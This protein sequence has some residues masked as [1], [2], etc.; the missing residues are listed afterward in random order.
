VIAEKLPESLRRELFA[1][2][3]SSFKDKLFEGQDW[4]IEMLRIANQKVK[5]KQ[6]QI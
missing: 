1:Y 6:M 3:I 5:N 2:S 4:H